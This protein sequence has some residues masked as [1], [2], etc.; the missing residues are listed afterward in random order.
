MGPLQKLPFSHYFFRYF[1][2]NISDFKQAS[3]R[4]LLISITHST[5]D[6]YK[7]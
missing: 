1:L 7:I 4:S 6:E 3:L 5:I 2:E